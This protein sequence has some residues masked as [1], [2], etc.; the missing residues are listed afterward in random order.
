MQKIILS[1]ISS[2]II[3]WNEIRNRGSNGKERIKKRR[4]K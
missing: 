4:D 2:Y 1:I 3:I